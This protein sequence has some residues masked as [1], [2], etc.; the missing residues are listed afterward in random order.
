MSQQ[1]LLKYA[2]AVLEAAGI[3]YMITGSTVS[4]LQ[5]QPR[6]THDID[7]VVGIRPS[8]IPAILAAF[9]QPKFY[10]DEDAIRDAI[11]HSFMFNVIDVE[12]GDK[13]DFWLLKS[14]PFDRTSFHRRYK[15]S[16]AGTEMFISQPEDTILRKLLW[17]KLGGG[18]EKQKVDCIA[19]YEVNYTNLDAQYM[20][21]WATELGILDLLQEIQHEANP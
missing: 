1:E 9:P 4:S 7:I 10:V 15:E 6:T 18:S 16:A 19:V 17:S 11:A 21:E 14:E 20:Q 13:I 2:V 5:G 3:P 8:T 12:G